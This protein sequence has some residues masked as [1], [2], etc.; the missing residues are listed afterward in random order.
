MLKFSGWPH[1]TPWRDTKR[2]E[3]GGSEDRRLSLVYD[4]R[5]ARKR[6]D[7]AVANHAHTTNDHKYALLAHWLGG[8]SSED[9]HRTDART[10][11]A[12]AT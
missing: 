11:P 9:A 1:V 6:H 4:G 3:A 2:E 10:Q 5:I 12:V 7:H 8:R